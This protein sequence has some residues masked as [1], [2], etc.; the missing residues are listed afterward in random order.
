MIHV[1]MWLTFFLFYFRG[2]GRFIGFF[3]E[4]KTYA[5]CKEEIVNRCCTAASLS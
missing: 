1:L 2:Q 4:P 3:E 5:L